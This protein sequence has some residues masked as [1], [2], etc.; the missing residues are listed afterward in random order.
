MIIASRSW[1]AAAIALGTAFACASTE[2]GT[3]PAAGGS[4]GSDASA[5]GA[6]GEA[7]GGSAGRASGGAAGAVA[8]SAGSA[9]SAGT[10]T[11]FGGFPV[12]L[13]AGAPIT[14]SGS[15]M[16][17]LDQDAPV[18][19]MKVCVY[20]TTICTESQAD[21][22]YELPGVPGNQELLIEFTRDAYYPVIRTLVTSDRDID[23][24]RVW[25]PTQADIEL[26]ALTL[27]NLQ[28]DPNK[29]ILL[30]LALRRVQ[31]EAGGW[32]YAGQSGVVASLSPRSGDGPFYTSGGPLPLP[33]KNLTQTTGSGLAIFAN[34]RPGV[35]EVDLSH[36]TLNCVLHAEAWPGA[37]ATSSRVPI[38]PGYATGG[39]AVVCEP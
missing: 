11:G 7:S 12:D 35:P 34:V 39:P 23:M 24:G 20:E 4:G 14:L 15:T 10:A 5:A 36:P 33:E 28:I 22:S 16:Q 2:D 1:G 13:D 32:A 25:F 19:G 8:G 21:G 18:V 26:V 38:L 17:L 31:T 37:T 27:D 6:A 3:G 29:G 9:G 30:A